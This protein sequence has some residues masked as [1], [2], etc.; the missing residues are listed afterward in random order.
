MGQ[1]D[2]QIRSNSGLNDNDLAGLFSIW[3][4][5]HVDA[6]HV[7]ERIEPAAVNKMMQHAAQF[8]LGISRDN[9]PAGFY[10]AYSRNK[11]NV[12]LCFDEKREKQDLRARAALP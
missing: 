3:V 4:G 9:V 2:A 6:D 11:S 10:L 1:L 12:I 7:I 5:S 8:R